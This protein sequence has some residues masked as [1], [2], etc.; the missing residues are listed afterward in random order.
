MGL[1]TFLAGEFN[2]VTEPERIPCAEPQQLLQFNVLV[3]DIMSIGKRPPPKQFGL[4]PEND[5]TR[6]LHHSDQLLR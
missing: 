3:G 6:W 2:N 1:V 5:G 4:P